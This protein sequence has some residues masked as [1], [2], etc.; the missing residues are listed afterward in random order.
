ME[1]MRKKDEELEDIIIRVIEIIKD[2]P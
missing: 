1:D 2:I